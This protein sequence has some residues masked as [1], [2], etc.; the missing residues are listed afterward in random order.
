MSD[1]TSLFEVN[2]LK[3]NII[4]NTLDD[5]CASLKERGY[6]PYNQIAGYII[7]GDPGYISNYHYAREKILELDRSEVVKLILQEFMEK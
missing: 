6:D 2:K 1:E 5:V 3:E 4:K 7:S